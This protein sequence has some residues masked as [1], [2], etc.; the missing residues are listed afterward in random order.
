MA[1]VQPLDGLRY[2]PARV[3]DVGQVLAPPY[4]VITP[5][6][7]AELYARSPYNVI[8]LILPREAERAASA[9]R[10]LREWVAA[11]L[12]RPDP[13]PALYLYSQQFSLPDGST[14]RRDGLLCR[15]R[16]E[17]FASG[18]VR[19][20]ERTLP[21]PKADRLAILRATGANLSA[22]FGLYD[23][24]GEP[25]R[26]LLG[27]APG[28]PLVDVNGWH[29]LWRVTDPATIARVQAA[30]ASESVIIAD[31]HHRYE[32]ALAYRDEQPGNEA[33]RYVLAYLANMEEE[34]VVILPTHRLV[35]GP[36][37]LDAP[38]LEA[39]LRA[40]FT[41][42]PLD[43]RRR[44][45]AG[46]IDCV[47]PDRKLRLRAGPAARARLDGLPPVLRDLEVE[48]LRRA[49]LE[50]V[51]DTG[52]EAL[53]FTHDDEEAVAA[54]AAG[55]A[56]VAFLLNPPSMAQVRQVCLAG[57]VMPEKSTYFYPKLATGLVFSL[58][59]PPWI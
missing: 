28:T 40:S 13:V 32:T 30:L 17:D 34:G 52:A 15:L 38:A 58:V 43:P 22:I 29:Q 59:G 37:R 23:R 41:V 19:P 16:L 53:D 49:I 36:L 25:L 46:E 2:D 31:G 10:T 4:D 39:R 11:D 45:A 51:L 3:G 5:A 1:V 48:L 47:L 24:P 54:V 8:R 55:R 26:E 50:P 14:R 56:A 12:L 20:H 35:R 6:E 21:G 7:Q 18:V 27:G 57:E 33:A 9:A 42:E 44:R